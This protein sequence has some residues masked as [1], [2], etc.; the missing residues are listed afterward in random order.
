M[1]WVSPAMAIGDYTLGGRLF[2]LSVS[3]DAGAPGGREI[4]GGMLRDQDVA[5]LAL[6][7]DLSPRDPRSLRDL[8]EALGLDAPLATRVTNIAERRTAVLLIDQLDALGELMD[9]YGSRLSMLFLSSIGSRT[10]PTFTS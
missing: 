2:T 8:E 9:Q 1:I 3:R 10:L 5:L 4:G 6:K 7:A